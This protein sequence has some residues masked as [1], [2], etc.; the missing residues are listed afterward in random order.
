MPSIRGTPTTAQNGNPGFA[1]NALTLNVPTYVAND[2]LIAQ[3]VIDSASPA[4]TPPAGWTAIG[5]LTASTNISMLTYW[6]VAGSEP[7][8][9][10]WNFGVTAG[11]CGIMS[12]WSG[13]D[14]GTP[15][16]AHGEQANASSATC[17]APS[18]TTTVDGCQVLFIGCYK[19]KETWAPPT[20]WILEAGLGGTLEPTAGLA[21]ATQ[22]THGAT[23]SKFTTLGTAANNIGQLVALAPSLSGIVQ[24]A[25]HRWGRSNR[26]NPGAIIVHGGRRHHPIS[27]GLTAHFAVP[28]A[29]HR[30]SHQA[31]FPIG[32]SFLRGRVVRHPSPPRGLGQHAQPRIAQKRK[33]RPPQA[34]P[35][36]RMK[37]TVKRRPSGWHTA[38]QRQVQALRRR[39][40]RPWKFSVVPWKG[41]VRRQRVPGSGLTSIVWVTRHRK[42]RSQPPG[43]LFNLRGRSR[44]RWLKLT[45]G[46]PRPRRI[47]GWSRRTAPVPFAGRIVRPDPQKPVRGPLPRRRQ[48]RQKVAPLWVLSKPRRRPVRGTGLTSKPTI[49]RRRVMKSVMPRMLG[50]R[51]RRRGPGKIGQTAIRRARRAIRAQ[52][53][54]VPVL[55]TR[56][57]N[58]RR[59]PKVQFTASPRRRRVVA[60]MPILPRR[61]SRR[62][63]PGLGAKRPTLRPRRTLP[64]RV[65]ALKSKAKRN[66]VPGTGLAQV[67]GAGSS[68]RHRLIRPP[69][70]PY[71]ML[72]GR[73]RRGSGTIARNESPPWLSNAGQVIPGPYW[74]PA[75]QVF[76]PGAVAADIITEG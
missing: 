32:S 75:A 50:G 16:N 4:I 52:W 37:G 69:K 15:V 36:H 12:A 18:I 10:T 53:P 40:V 35:P 34:P 54:G 33:G 25:I 62:R 72:T 41:K 60:K 39:V 57:T 3:I 64:Y 59:T 22:S 11:N 61:N 73:G 66:K 46:V 47:R 19:N 7:A 2:I 67:V 74:V 71:N 1:T 43:N 6:R 14:T 23:G 17:T 24:T 45:V 48:I 8:S 68:P 56:A 20:G 13:C 55:R 27:T 63:L 5:S 42:Q 76:S 38:A 58:R 30:A 9:Y 26:W 65:P 49:F 70:F 31:P 51:V 21:D 28:T 29:R 44:R